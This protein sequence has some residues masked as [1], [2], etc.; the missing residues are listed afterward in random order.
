MWQHYSQD[1]ENRFG[2]RTSSPPKSLECAEAGEEMPPHGSLRTEDTLLLTEELVQKHIPL[3]GAIA[4]EA[5]RSAIDGFSVCDQAKADLT[6]EYARQM[7]TGGEQ[8]AW[9]EWWTSAYPR[10]RVPPNLIHHPERSYRR[11]HRLTGQEGLNNLIQ[12]LRKMSPEQGL[13]QKVE[14]VRLLHIKIREMSSA[15]TETELQIAKTLVKYPEKSYTEIAGITGYSSQW[16]AENIRKMKRRG[17]LREFQ[18]VRFSKVGIRMF[19]VLLG[20]SEHETDPLQLLESC[21]FLYGHR[22]LLTGWW[23]LHAVLTVP[24]SVRSMKAVERFPALANRWKVEVQISEVK[25]SG[26][27]YSFNHYDCNEGQWRIPW[28]A[29]REAAVELRDGELEMEG[30]SLEPAEPVIKYKLDR[31]DIEIMDAIRRL[32]PSIAAIRADVQASQ[33]KVARKVRK[34]RELGV[35]TTRWEMHNIGLIEGCILRARESAA[36]SALLSWTK[37]LPRSIVSLDGEGGLFVSSYLPMGGGYGAIRAA[38]GLGPNVTTDL[39]GDYVYGGWGF[40]AELWDKDRQLWTEP[41]ERIMDWAES[42]R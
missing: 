9:V 32:V 31:L 39:V 3:Q 1:I 25:S 41:S 42:L 34:L 37:F 12:V 19:N 10:E 40:P 30:V 24:D 23:N 7:L 29:L 16:V 18:Q 21:P 2:L 22:R 17:V 13:L 27:D 33:N 14:Y 20:S 8:E 11:L 38:K 6:M 26:T 36:V 28:L 15:L 35:I 4:A 5:L